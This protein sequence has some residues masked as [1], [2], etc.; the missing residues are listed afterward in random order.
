MAS[1]EAELKKN[2]SETFWKTVAWGTIG[3]IAIVAAIDIL[4]PQ[5]ASL[6]KS[7]SAS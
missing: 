2:W 1:P 3:V 6:E 5:I 7:L 4:G